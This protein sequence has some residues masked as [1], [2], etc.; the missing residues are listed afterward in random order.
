MD[1][2]QQITTANSV[3]S[4]KIDESLKYQRALAICLYKRIKAITKYESTINIK[5]KVILFK[6]TVVSITLPDEDYGLS[7]YCNK[8]VEVRVFDGNHVSILENDDVASAI[9][10]LF[11]VSDQDIEGKGDLL[12]NV[13]KVH[14]EVPTKL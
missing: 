1:L 4:S 6:P 9:N 7:K 8:P 10:E 5:S 13:D 3:R 12:I 11:G 2:C 14:K